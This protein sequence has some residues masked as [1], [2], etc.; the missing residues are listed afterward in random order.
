MFIRV[1]QVARRKPPKPELPPDRIVV[2]ISDPELGYMRDREVTAKDI[3][4]QL[5]SRR[6]I[7]QPMFNAGRRF[8]HYRY[9]VE[10]IGGLRGIDTTREPVDGSGAYPEPIT[11]SQQIARKKLIAAQSALGPYGYALVESVLWRGLSIAQAAAERFM[12]SKRG[13]LYIGRRLNECLDTL[14]GLHG[15]FDDR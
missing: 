14:R 11:D 13:K 9:R 5:L 12:V 3:L 8:Q 10:G 7:D 1:D 6:E 2:A 4:W 15:W